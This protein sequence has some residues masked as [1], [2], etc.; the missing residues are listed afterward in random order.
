VRV[1]RVAI[2]LLPHLPIGIGREVNFCDY[3]NK[4]ALQGESRVNAT[5]Q[6]IVLPSFPPWLNSARLS[7]A[8]SHRGLAPVAPFLPLLQRETLC[9][10]VP[11][12]RGAVLDE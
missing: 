12:R 2:R 11:G 10:C 3:S 8:G 7:A 1:K 5:R 6:A 9:R 4:I